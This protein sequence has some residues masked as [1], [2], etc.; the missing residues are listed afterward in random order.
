VKLPDNIS[1][2]TLADAKTGVFIVINSAHA[3]LRRR[4]SLAH[5]YAHVLI[6]RNRAGTLSRT[7]NR[8]DLLEVRANAFAAEFLIPAQGVVQFVQALGKGAATRA[9][10]AVFDG[11][12]VVQVEQHAA[13]ES[14]DIQLYDVALLSHHFGVSRNAIIYRLKNLRLIDEAGLQRLLAREHAGEGWK[15]AD[16]LRAP[17][18]VHGVGQRDDFRRRFLGLALEAYRRAEITR[19][20]LNELASIVGVEHQSIGQTLASVGLD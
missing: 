18:P 3:P 11:T 9:R 20:K 6:D 15:I 16:F 14:Q 13:P 12:D 4:F 8:A 17:E 19:N 10:I 7:E 5:E 2:L 1:G